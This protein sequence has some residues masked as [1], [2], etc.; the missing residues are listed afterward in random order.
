MSH[1]IRTPMNG[2]LG[3]AQLMRRS[4]PQSIAITPFAH[5][6][7][8]VVMADPHQLENALLNL[9][10]NARDAMPNGGELRIE[11]SSETL[12]AAAAADIEAEPGDYV[13]ITVSDNGIGMDV[14]TLTR[15]FEPFFTTKQFGA[16]SGLGM[17]MVYGFVKQSGGGVLLRSRQARGTSVALLLP[18]TRQMPRG[19]ESP[20]PALPREDVRGQLVL[21]VEDNPEV[22]KVARLLLTDLGY[23][24]LEAENALEAADMIEN[25]PDIA[26]LLSDIVMPG[27]MD[28]AALARFARRF[29]PA[30]RI[31]LVSGYAKGLEDDDAEIHG[32]RFL[33]KPFTREALAQALRD[34]LG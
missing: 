29:R 7:D 23:P 25:I 26:I 2:M 5:E 8:L 9:A 31:V 21:L 10:L 16:G 30:M 32:F 33:P 6:D 14:G 4:L 15:V 24:V 34:T 27:G 19:A 12:D 18:R 3:M 1:E 17:S 22:R 13:Q 20:Q 28:G 11:S